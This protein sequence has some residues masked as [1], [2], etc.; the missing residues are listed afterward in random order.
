MIDNHHHEQHS[1]AGLTVAQV[2]ELMESEGI[3]ASA[4]F[5]AD[6]GD[7]PMIPGLNGECEGQFIM[8]PVLSW[9]V[10]D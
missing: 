2:A 1:V 4:V 6:E 5:D 10:E 9:R 8:E 7:R 3:P